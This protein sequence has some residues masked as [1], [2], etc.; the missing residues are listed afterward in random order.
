V[1]A[2]AQLVLVAASAV[3]E[4]EEARHRRRAARA[5]RAARPG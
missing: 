2:P 1:V 3:A 5:A 4:G